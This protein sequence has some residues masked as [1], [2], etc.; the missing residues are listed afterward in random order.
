VA[1]IDAD[2]DGKA[3]VAVGSGVGQPA[4][5]R[6]YRGA[7]LAGGGEPA[8]Q[9]LDPFGGAVMTDGVYVG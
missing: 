4:R 9:D 5:V 1:V 3:D 8:S 7:D 6:V 2:G